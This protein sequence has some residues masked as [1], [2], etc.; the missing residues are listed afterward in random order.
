M[1]NQGQSEKIKWINKGGP[2]TTKDK[3]EISHGQTFMA[4]PEDVPMGFRDVIIPMEPLPE[5][6]PLE[7]V[8]PQYQIVSRGPG[9][10]NVV[11]GNGKVKNEKPLKQADAKALIESLS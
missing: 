9:W 11:D 3:R 2:F 4:S 8:A 7:V 5:E 1:T 10:F 6:R